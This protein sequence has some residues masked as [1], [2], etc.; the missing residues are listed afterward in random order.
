MD[1]L[2]TRIALDFLYRKSRT[3]RARGLAQLDATLGPPRPLKMGDA[4]EYPG[5]LRLEV[6][7]SLLERIE[8]E[9]SMFAVGC[10]QPFCRRALRLPGGLFLFQRNFFSRREP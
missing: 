2:V 1:R 5:R 3:V 6:L 9:A 8:S 4:P 10:G 7:G